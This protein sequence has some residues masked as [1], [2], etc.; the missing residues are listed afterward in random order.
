MNTRLNSMIKRILICLVGFL[1]ISSCSSKNNDKTKAQSE[2]EIADQD[3][4]Q[5]FEETI[6]QFEYEDSISGPLELDLMLTGSSSIRLWANIEDDLNPYTLKNRG[7]GGA[8][9]DELT[10]YAPRFL[11]THNYKCLIV[12]CGENDISEGDSP[13]EAFEDFKSFHTLVRSRDEQLPILYVSMKPSIARANLYNDFI[14]A[15]SLIIEY[16]KSDPQSHIFDSGKSMIVNDSLRMDI[17]IE[18]GLHMNQRGYDIWAENI[19]SD[20][21]QIFDS[22]K[23]S[24]LNSR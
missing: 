23:K 13:G 21:S 24:T 15:D 5:R 2:I 20:L 7:F 1:L 4:F 11:F 9:L 18:D 12:Y 8:T 22:S 14:S 19:K 3:D 16:L 10:H 6:R 17:F